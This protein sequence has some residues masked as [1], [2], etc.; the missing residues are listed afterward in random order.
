MP[1]QS[2]VGISGRNQSSDVRTV[3][4]LLNRQGNTRYSYGRITVDGICGPQTTG[5]ISNYQRTVVGFSSPDGRV[6][7]G[8]QTITAL[9]RN[10]SGSAGA[11]SSSSHDRPPPPAPQIRLSIKHGGKTPTQTGSPGMFES[12]F[13]VFV[14]EERHVFT[15]SIYPDDMTNYGRIKNGFYKLNLCFHKRNGTPTHADLV[16]KNNSNSLRPALTI[17]LDQRVPI[18]SDSP[19]IQTSG[20]L[21][22][23]NGFDGSSRGSNGCITVKP[24]DWARFIQM[25]L[26]W[27]P[28]LGDWCTV[29]D[30]QCT[31]YTGREVGTL[32]VMA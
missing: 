19:G 5:A 22:V 18:K 24:N 10:A 32:E 6:D 21:H 3:Q 29:R 30:G 23:H 12:T 4:D 11:P 28:D 20:N 14:E 25:F 16:V 9:E 31:C 17:E 13:S 1:I 26:D 15:G 7:P 27:Y 8:G 2:S